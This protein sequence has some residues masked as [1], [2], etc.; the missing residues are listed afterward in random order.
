MG[1][2]LSLSWHLIFCPIIPIVASFDTRTTMTLQ[3]QQS[4]VDTNKISRPRGK[5]LNTKGNELV[6]DLFAENNGL[7]RSKH[8][9]VITTQRKNSVL[10]EICEKVNALVVA[11][12]TVAQIKTKWSNRGLLH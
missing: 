1:A 8:N 9:S 6:L 12:R 5:N 11:H 2:K 7:L 4:S 3:Q 10:R